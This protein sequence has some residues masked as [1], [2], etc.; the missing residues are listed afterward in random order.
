MSG[1]SLVPDAANA[2]EP[3][4]AGAWLETWARGQ[5]FT[6]GVIFLFVRLVIQASVSMRAVPRALAVV[7]ELFGL[8]LELPHWTTGRSWLLRVGYYKLM[9]PKEQAD[10]WVLIIDHSC[11]SGVEKC[12]VILGLR[13]RNLPPPGECLCLQHLE[14]LEILP[15]RSSTQEDVAKQLSVVTAKIGMPRAI[16]RDGGSD[17]RGGVEL[18]QRQHPQTADICDIKHKAACLLK[19][20][21]EADERWSAF[22]RAVATAR[23]QMQ[24]TELAFLVPPIQ[25]TKARYMNLEELM[26]WSVQTLTIMDTPPARVLQHVTMERL[27]EKLGWLRQYR[28][29]LAEWSELMAV[30]D[31]AEHFVRTEGLYVGGAWDMAKRRPSGLSHASSQQLWKDLLR[32]VAEQTAQVRPGERLPGSTEILE[33]CFGK[34]KQLEKEQRR[35]GFTGLLLA[36]GAEV[37]ETSAEL[38][39]AALENCPLKKVWRWCKEKLGDTIQSK[40]RMAYAPAPA[41]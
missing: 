9:R 7:R 2:G 14:P 32:H 30:T 5:H 38:V 8:T 37:S 18:F 35:S 23:C 29:A 34:F 21:L 12:L 17:L 31:V 10:D 11:Q 27:D 20:T 24:Q 3:M 26:R 40:R 6:V 4:V 41:Q 1:G 36:L 16:L 25:R 19:H 15:V 39:Q 22:N 33:S 28:D 13:L